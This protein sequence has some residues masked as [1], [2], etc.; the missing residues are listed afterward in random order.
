M[1]GLSGR[2]FRN[3]WVRTFLGALLL[4]VIVWFFGPLLG[5]GSLHPLDSDLAR[6]I[7]IAV[8]FVGWLVENLVHQLRAAKHDKDLVDGVAAQAKDPNETASAEEVAL[9]ADRL[10]EALA[11]LKKAKLGRGSG[12]YL[13]QLPWYMF[14]GPPGAG[15][16]WDPLESTCRHA[17][18]SIL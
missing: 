17:S 2:I 16:T 12:G 1:R 18:L 15:K 13:Y 7:A 14:I 6:I 8:I 5:F 4:S 9:L 11:A 10:K 3:R